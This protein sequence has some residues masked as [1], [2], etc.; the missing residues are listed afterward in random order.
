MRLRGKTALVFGAGS[1][2]EG[3]GNGKAAAIA[4]ARAGANVFVVD[5]SR[6]AANQTRDMIRDEGFLCE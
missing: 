5:L 4:Y 1:N 3:I 6:V 2:G